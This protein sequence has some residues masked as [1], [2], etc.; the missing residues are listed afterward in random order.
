MRDDTPELLFETRQAFRAWLEQ[1]AAAS[2]GVW[3]VFGKART[4]PTLTANDALEE[5]L[6]RPRPGRQ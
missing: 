3:L 4:V 1:N 6:C 5:A 2:D